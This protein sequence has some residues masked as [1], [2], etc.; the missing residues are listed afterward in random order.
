MKERKDEV[1]ERCWC[2]TCIRKGKEENEHENFINRTEALQEYRR[3]E[4][5]KITVKEEEDGK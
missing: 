3:G 1:E 5:N 2:W 4:K